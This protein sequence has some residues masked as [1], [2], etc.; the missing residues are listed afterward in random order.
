MYFYVSKGDGS[1]KALVQAMQSSDILSFRMQRLCQDMLNY[2]FKPLIS[3]SCHLQETENGIYMKVLQHDHHPIRPLEVLLNLERVLYLIAKCFEF[4]TESQENFNSIIG[5]E[6]VEKLMDFLLKNCLYPA[7]P[8]KKSLLEDFNG[9]IN[10]VKS[11]ESTLVDLKFTENTDKL[12]HFRQNIHNT[13]VTQRCTSILVQARKLMKMELHQTV[14]LEQKM[15]MSYEEAE[16]TF[17][18]EFNIDMDI[19]T[20]VIFNNLLK[21]QLKIVIIVILT[22]NNHENKFLLVF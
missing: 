1:L 3:K 9:V 18:T 11:F 10:G 20:C 16:T 19:G 4:E 13:F 14:R 21:K 22:I 17:K 8:D 2:V 6:I 7:V 12:T 15:S 5:I